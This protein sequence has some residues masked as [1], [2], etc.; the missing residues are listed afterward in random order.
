[1]RK[2]AYIFPLIGWRKVEH[3]KANIEALS[4]VLDAEDL[5]DIEKAGDWSPGF[6]YDVLAFG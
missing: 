5:R 1:M 3:L 4:V 6:T 2:Q